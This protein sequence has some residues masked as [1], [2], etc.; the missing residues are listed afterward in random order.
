MDDKLN[1]DLVP[2]EEAQETVEANAAE[3]S[4]AAESEPS[5][6]SK[7]E[8]RFSKYPSPDSL[9]VL[10]ETK[11]Q[12]EALAAYRKAYEAF[13]ECTDA[14]EMRSALFAVNAKYYALEL[15]LPLLRNAASANPEGGAADVLAQYEKSCK[16]GKTASIVFLVAFLLLGGVFAATRIF[17]NIINIFSSGSTQ[18]FGVA[19]MHIICLVI[20]VVLTVY[21]ALEVKNLFASMGL[22]KAQESLADIG[23]VPKLEEGDYAEA[24]DIC[25]HCGENPCRDGSEYCSE[26]EEKLLSTKVPFIGWLAGAGAIVA[27]AFATV[28]LFFIIAP[29][30]NGISGEIAAKEKRWDDAFGYYYEMNSTTAQFASYYETL[31]PFIRTG[32]KVKANLVKAYAGMSGP[33]EAIQRGDY[34]LD[35]TSVLQSKELAPIMDIYKRYYDTANVYSAQMQSVSEDAG[36]EE[37]KAVLE[38]CLG[39]DKVD[40][41]FIYMSLYYLA[42]GEKR[43]YAEQIGYLKKCEETAAA[44]GYDYKWL[45]NYDYARLCRATGDFEGALARYKELTEANASDIYSCINLAKT[46]MA[47]GKTAEAEAMLKELVDEKGKIDLTYS[48]EAAI[49]RMKGD[50]AALEV[51]CDTAFKEYD[52]APEVHHQ[53]AIACLLQG[54]YD[55]AYQHANMADYNGY[56]WASQGVTKAYADEYTTVLYLAASL[57]VK[58][59]GADAAEAKETVDMLKEYGFVENA[60]VTAILG[61]TKTLEE[62]FMKG[63]Y[64]IL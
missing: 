56:Y 2:E 23:G 51:L 41:S 38:K 43:P 16:K 57:C 18:N 49:L 55:D 59:N 30:F 14:K 12:E 50:Y 34:Y 48:I 36:Y 58:N 19:I 33:L 53:Y 35:D 29:S 27:S 45:Y 17:P 28:L 64:D 1:K 54:R 24:A 63:A 52:N 8:K 25:V 26:C 61:G 3:D 60:D 11:K 37:N 22:T 32:E 47:L 42:A 7:I 21:A 40:D 5:V 15:T 10:V 62:V 13:G 44:N 46:Y 6:N 31:S 9:E 39:M 4:V 20:Y